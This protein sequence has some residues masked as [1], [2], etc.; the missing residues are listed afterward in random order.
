MLTPVQKLQ[1]VLL[2]AERGVVAL[3]VQTDQDVQQRLHA[4]ALAGGLSRSVQDQLLQLLQTHLSRHGSGGCHRGGG[5]V[6]LNSSS[7]C[8]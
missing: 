2:P 4:Q 3:V 6:E 1:N 5:E 8:S 7:A